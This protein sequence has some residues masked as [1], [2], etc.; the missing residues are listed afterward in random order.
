MAFREGDGDEDDM[1]VTLSDSSLAN[2][3]RTTFASYF[4]EVWSR[5]GYT[6]PGIDDRR[7]CF[8]FE[9]ASPYNRVVVAYDDELL[10]LH[11]CRSLDNLAEQEPLPFAKKYDWLLAKSYEFRSLDEVI[12]ASRKLDASKAEGFV[13]RD[14]NFQRVKVKSPMYVQVALLSATD[15]DGLNARRLLE[16][17]QLNEGSEFLSY[18]PQW[19]K[20]YSLIQEAYDRY[21]AMIEN[22]YE[23]LKNLDAKEFATATSKVEGDFKSLLFILKKGQSTLREILSQQQ[24]KRLLDLL[25]KHAKLELPAN[26]GA[27]SPLVVSSSK[28]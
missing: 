19:I 3:T 16:V 21:I 11:G 1:P 22:E 27:D 5:K 4:W 28:F 18:F 26:N 2:E 15:K 13:I 25:K 20:L 6:L 7:L 23:P 17:L 24:S 14:S 12:T 9:L 8:M 10:T